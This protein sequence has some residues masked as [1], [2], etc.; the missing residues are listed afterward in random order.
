MN[1]LKIF[2]KEELYKIKD[3]NRK[4]HFGYF[5]LFE[6]ENFLKIGSTKNPYKRIQS[7]KC[8]VT[9]YGQKETGRLVLSVP[10]TNYRNNEKELHRIFDNSR[11]GKSELFDI[12]LEEAIK[13]LNKV[14]IIY[15]DRSS[16]YIDK[17]SG[18]SN[19]FIDYTKG[20]YNYILGGDE[21]KDE[22]F[23]NILKEKYGNTEYYDYVNAIGD[24]SLEFQLIVFLL[25][26]IDSLNQ[27]T[28]YL[29][30]ECARLEEKIN[31][32]LSKD[33]LQFVK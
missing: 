26:R 2:N 25:G 9:N 31:S 8:Q 21:M 18:V 32:I 12:S 14:D 15:E 16:S 27:H 19:F 4:E 30:E 3:M 10:H 13:A 22:Y 29:Y 20:E 23:L 1:D 24:S 17:D 5:Y 6:L 33:E 28:S 11:V 7:L